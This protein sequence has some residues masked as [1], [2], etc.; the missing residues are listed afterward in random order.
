MIQI[1]KEIVLHPKQSLIARDTSRFKVIR[2][3]RRF[4]KS[5]LSVTLLISNAMKKKGMYY[6]VAPYYRQAKEIGWKMLHDLLPKEAILKT[7]E[8]ELSV[9]LLNGSEIKL[10]GAD[11]P[12]SLKGV[13]LSG[14]I[15]DEYAF[16]KPSVWEE[17]IRPMLFDTGG[18]CIFISTPCGYNHFF[19]LWE[20]ATKENWSRFHFTTYDNPH[21]K[22][23]EIEEAKL[24]MSSERFDQEIMSEFNKKSGACWPMFSRD[25]HVVKRQQPKGTIYASIDFGFALGHK[26]AFLLH[27]VVGETVHTF[28]GF[29]VEQETIDQIDERMKTLTGGLIIQGLFPDPARPDL[30][31]ELKRRNWPILTTNKDVEIGIAKVSEYMNV[32]PLTNKVRWTLADHLTDAIHQIEEYQWTEVRGEDGQ[33]T[34]RPKKEKDDYC[35]SLRYFM[36][37]YLNQ[38]YKETFIPPFEMIGGGYSEGQ[39]I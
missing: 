21:I 8:T 38:E 6:F 3:G 7:N 16:M 23:E 26:T 30:I 20:S 37:S 11:N 39:Y 28:D 5:Y 24:A 19:D 2:C 31:E 18:W 35:D 12:D 27:D 10:K 34:Q 13:G 15:L 25:V 22:P 33:Y 4:G 1:T 14:C 32:N 36:N 17:I 29:G 9:E